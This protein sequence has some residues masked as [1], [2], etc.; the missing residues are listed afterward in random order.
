MED[1]R[2]DAELLRAL[3]D[4]DQAAYAVLW[5]RHIG[6]ALRYAHRLFPSR[7][8]DLA[9]EALLAVYQQV[10]TTTAGPEFAFRSYLKAVIRNTAIR[11]RKE[12]DHID[13]TVEPD[14]AD[15]RDALSLVEREVN[16]Q[17]FLGAF[18]ELPER[19]Q[20][21]LWLTEV[22]E[23][24]RPEVARELGIKPN[25]V[26]A[27]QRRARSGLKLQWLT[28][29]I[30]LALRDDEAHVARLFPRH[31][32]EPLDDIV[33]QEVAGHVSSCNTCGELLLT[34]RS[35]AQRLHGVTLSA[36]GFGALG[37]IL[38][39]TG[40]FAP[41]TAVAAAVVATGAG[42]G[43]ASLLAGGIG[44]LTVGTLILGSFLLPGA[45][46]AASAPALAE[47]DNT[48]SSHAG[49]PVPSVPV[50]DRTVVTPAPIATTPPVLPP[51]TGRWNSDPAID[52]V[53]LID[54]PDAPQP[55]N[56]TRPGTAPVT[57]PGPGETPIPTLSPGLTTPATHSGYFAPALAGKATPGSSVGIDVNDRRYTPAVAA[58]G[59]WSFEPR[60]LELQ[61]GT[62]EYQTWAFDA[63]KQSAATSGSFTIEPIVVE[64]FEDIVGTED[65]LVDEA[66]TTGL[67]IAVTGPANETIHVGTMQG[68][69][70]MIPLDDTGHAVKRLRMHSRGWYWFTFR[71]MD[72]DGYLGAMQERALDVYDPDIIFDP[73]GP[74]PEEMTFELTDP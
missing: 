17:Q 10:T 5:E 20:R 55:L 12:A 1:S 4:G 29:Q 51:R 3:R 54:D 18:Q 34:L 52:S 2:G 73:W 21:V 38:P 24:S 68:H 9:S 59:T 6:A 66:S 13:D 62:Y 49:A 60:S 47:T 42:A 39:S 65:M 35:D 11:W 53:D 26:S 44:V 45:L 57:T 16:A 28:T 15:F 63:E 25:A 36:V 30:P 7:A 22:A 56:P 37:V 32:T 72:S 41:G 8:E 61:A 46:P 71:A 23:V 74:G 67:V 70:A 43:L 27:L 50:R 19:W 69:T 33:A 40:A 31:L 14:R 58:D 64:G 48:S